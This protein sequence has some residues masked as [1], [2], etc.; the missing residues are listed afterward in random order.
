[1]KKR[2]GKMRSRSLTGSEAPS[3]F[4]SPPGTFQP[5]LSRANEEDHV[6]TPIV[7]ASSNEMESGIFHRRDALIIVYSAKA[8]TE[9][10]EPGRNKRQEG[11]QRRDGYRETKGDVGGT[12][13]DEHPCTI[14][15][16]LSPFSKPFTPAPTLSTSPEQSHPT[17]NPFQLRQTPAC[18]PGE[19]KNTSRSVRSLNARVDV[20]SAFSNFP[21][22]H[23]SR[24][25]REPR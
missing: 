8:P 15:P 12:E 10:E 22:L 24:S 4:F 17:I 1:M 25:G 5:S 18:F 2:R 3:V 19:R 23:S 9:V 16:T 11:G 13:G 6:V 7:E 21:K 14:P 20:S